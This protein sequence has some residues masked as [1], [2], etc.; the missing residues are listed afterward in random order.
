M[1]LS[2]GVRVSIRTLVRIL[3]PLDTLSFMKTSY[4]LPWVIRYHEG[5]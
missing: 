3:L 1:E 5:I 2:K 4:A